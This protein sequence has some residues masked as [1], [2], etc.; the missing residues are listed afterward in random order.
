MEKNKVT[1]TKG[2]TV[3]FITIVAII[4]SANIYSQSSVTPELK[5]E[6]IGHYEMANLID[7]IPNV[8]KEQLQEMD[9]EFVIE[10]DVLEHTY[11]GSD[12]HYMYDV[13]L[14]SGKMTPV[15]NEDGT[16]KSI[17]DFFDEKLAQ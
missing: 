16:R 14:A 12:G 6:Y 9:I 3:I 17:N 2:L 15:M 8:D 4:I 5:P 11:K 10:C 13:D 1:G 7:T